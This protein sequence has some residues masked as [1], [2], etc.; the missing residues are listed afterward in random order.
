LYEQ[1]PVQTVVEI[2]NSDWDLEQKPVN[3]S[4]NGVVI[5]N[6]QFRAYNNRK[7]V[8]VPARLLAQTMGFTVDW[9]DGQKKITFVYG[10]NAMSA[11][12]GSSVIYHNSVMKRMNS[13]AVLREGE[14][15][16]PVRYLAESLGYCV[17]WDGS[18]NTVLLSSQSGTAM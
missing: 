18:N 3:I 8:M 12:I 2:I 15:W 11:T 17:E 4:F 5:K 6:P 7:Q 16:L 13:T 1:V 9:P 10:N 14:V